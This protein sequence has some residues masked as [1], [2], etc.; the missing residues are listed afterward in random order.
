MESQQE[1]P[2][3]FKND[4]RVPYG[5]NLV[6][7]VRSYGKCVESLAKYKNHVMFNLFWKPSRL[8]PPSLRIRPPMKTARART[9]AEKASFN[10]LKECVRLS[11][12]R[13]QQLEDERKWTAIGLRRRMNNK[14]FQ[15]VNQLSVKRGE[16]AFAVQQKKNI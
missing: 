2:Y 9:I 15:K 7:L 14:D 5:E 1:P 12:T 3:L 6:S 8:I 4:L 13:K 11:I 10:F 16:T